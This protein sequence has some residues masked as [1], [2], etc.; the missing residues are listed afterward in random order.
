MPKE[1]LKVPP[2]ILALKAP[3][4]ICG[5]KIP[6]PAIIPTITLF[7]DNGER[8]ALLGQYC[9]NCT[10]RAVDLASEI[11]E[12]QGTGRWELFDIA[13]QAPLLQGTYGRK[14]TPEE[15]ARPS[16]ILDEERN[17]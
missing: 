16:L 1:K 12:A 17:G 8:V 6:L 5:N 4:Q 7:T 9:R 3:C 2:E 14:T 15:F 13:L 11:P 10:S